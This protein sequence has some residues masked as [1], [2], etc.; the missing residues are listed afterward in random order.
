MKN[1]IYQFYNEGLAII[2]C[3]KPIKYVNKKFKNKTL[4]KY[5][6][7]IITTFYT[8]FAICLAIILFK[9]IFPF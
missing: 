2:F 1:L 7:L 3:V 5:L 6:T 8:I 9:V 4:I